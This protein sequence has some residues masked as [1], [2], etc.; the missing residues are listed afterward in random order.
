MT[1]AEREA[2]SIARAIVKALARFE[3]SLHDPDIMLND[4][5]L[6]ARNESKG[7]KDAVRALQAHY[8]AH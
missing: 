1:T 2:A 3:R 6:Y 4:L 8:K 5:D 7:V